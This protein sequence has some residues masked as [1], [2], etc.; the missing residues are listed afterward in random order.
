MQPTKTKHIYTNNRAQVCN[1]KTRVTTTKTSKST[2]II[3]WTSQPRHGE[4][5][6]KGLDFLPQLYDVAPFCISLQ[7]PVESSELAILRRAVR[8]VNSNFD[9]PANI[10]VLQYKTADATAA[11]M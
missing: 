2:M 8:Q 10:L 5:C 4:I 6:G 3:F 7:V 11:H 9:T 1:I